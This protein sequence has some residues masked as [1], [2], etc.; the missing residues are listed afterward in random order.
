[1]D[2]LVFASVHTIASAILDKTVS[3]REV[4]QAHID[5]INA[6]NPAIN[7]LVQSTAGSALDRAD[8]ADSAIAKG[9]LLG[10]LH[11]VPFTVKDN[12]ETKGVICGCGT[13]GLVQNVP[14]E[15]AIVV[16]RIRGAGGILLGKTNLPELGLGYETDN[17]LYG[18]TNNPYDLSCTSGGSSGGEAA[19]IAAAGSPLGLATDGGGSARWPSHCC[20]VAGIKP[21]TGRTPKIGHVPPPGGVLNSLWQMSLMARSVTDLVLA[22]PIICGSHPRDPSSVPVFFPQLG[23]VDLTAVRIAVFTDNGIF[24]PIPEIV[25]M[26][27]QCA[28]S[29]VQAGATV[30][31][32]RPSMIVDAHEIYVHLLS[33]D[34]GIGLG[35]LLNEWGTTEAHS[36][37][38]RA[39]AAQ[40]RHQHST[41]EFGRWLYKLDQFRQC[42]SVFMANHDAILCPVA[43]LAA[44]AHGYTMPD[45][46]FAGFDPMFSYV[47][48]F[49]LTGWPCGTVRAGTSM[50]GLPLGIQVAANAWREDVVLAVLEYLEAEYGG[51]QPP[52]L[53]M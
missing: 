38:K 42:M 6:V 15:D 21:T 31:H 23:T 50:T 18:R 1:M 4:V 11:G 32:V 40:R 26:V 33:A 53:A 14:T 28:E 16:A 27:E 45:P 17:L 44:V 13:T 25:E 37:T 5:Q 19:L 35:E 36:Y 52:H 8:A 29:M 48:P 9:E 10:P 41:R 3:V 22:L 30:S 47:V 12:I 24:S 46:S 43:P 49:N 51:W 39:Q 20:G 7:A 34:G 2:Q